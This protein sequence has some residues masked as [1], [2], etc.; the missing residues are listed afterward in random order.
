MTTLPS[1]SFRWARFFAWLGILSVPAFM[2]GSG[3]AT[4]LPEGG[5]AINAIGAISILTLIIATIGTTSTILL[6]WRADARQSQEFKLKIEQLELQ[7]VEAREEAQ[8]Q[9][10]TSN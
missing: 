3:L 6:G 1:R 7:L 2:V 4:V 8:K 10:K 5:T 9:N